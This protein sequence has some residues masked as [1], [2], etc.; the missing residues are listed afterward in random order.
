MYEN[1]CRTISDVADAVGLSLRSRQLS[2]TT[3]DASA[4]D[5]A[6]ETARTK[7]GF[8]NKNVLVKNEFLKE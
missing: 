6:E 3:F 2:P 7:I 5:C 8:K 1:G 4:E